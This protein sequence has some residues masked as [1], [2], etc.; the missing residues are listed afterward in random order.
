MEVVAHAFERGTR[1]GQDFSLVDHL[2]MADLP[3]DEVRSR[4]GVPSRDR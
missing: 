3:L 2:A 1:T 4:Y